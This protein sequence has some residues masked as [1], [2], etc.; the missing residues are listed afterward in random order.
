MITVNSVAIYIVRTYVGLYIY[1][2]MINSKPWKQSVVDFF[3]VL[4]HMRAEARHS[5]LYIM[6][7]ALPASVS[8]DP[9]IQHKYFEILGHVFLLKM[10]CVC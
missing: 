6:G 3:P 7:K 4:C 1:M 10:C 5:F 2:V 9:H 8:R